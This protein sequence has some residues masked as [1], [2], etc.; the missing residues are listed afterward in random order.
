[1]AQVVAS[2]ITA[3]AAGQE[4][5]VRAV[6]ADHRCQAAEIPRDRMEVTVTEICRDRMEVTVTEKCRDRME[7]TVTEKCRGRMEA[8]VTERCQDL[9]KV[10]MDRN[11]MKIQK[12]MQQKML[13]Q[14]QKPV[15]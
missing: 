12:T 5:E 13:I 7:V 9:V 3:K 10:K 4:T 15:W 14:N 11:R 1:M 6:L 2:E 8:T